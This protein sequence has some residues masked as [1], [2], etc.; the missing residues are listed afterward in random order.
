MSGLEFI[1]Y[2]V[3]FLVLASHPP[4]LSAWLIIHP[5]SAFWRKLGGG[6]TVFI[7]SLPVVVWIAGV[8]ILRN[9]L[10]G[11]NLGTS[12]FTMALSRVSLAGAVWLR[13][14]RMRNPNFKRISGFPE[15]SRGNYPGPLLTDGIYARIRNPRY[16]EMLLLVLGLSLFANY[17][18]SYLAWLISLP[19]LFR[20]V[21]MEER[22]LRERFGAVY[23][24]YC[25]R[26]PRFIP[27][28]G[29]RKE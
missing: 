6:W 7:L 2:G 11:I 3:A 19:V 27:R 29:A 20:V 15:L 17:S 5:F 9:V 23:D 1:R 28:L 10:L 12:A 21:V 4:A 22:E 8:W 14:L 18:G 24:E 13:I 26:V 16:V 25:R